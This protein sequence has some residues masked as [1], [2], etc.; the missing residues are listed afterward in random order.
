MAVVVEVQVVEIQ[1]ALMDIGQE[2]AAA[3]ADTQAMAAM[4]QLLIIPQAE[5]AKEVAGEVAR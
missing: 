5:M 3:L 2:P 4:R 1:T